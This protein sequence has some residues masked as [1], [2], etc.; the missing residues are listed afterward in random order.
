MGVTCKL[1]RLCMIGFATTHATANFACGELGCQG[2]GG[3]GDFALQLLSNYNLLS[4]TPM[5]SSAYQLCNRKAQLR[6]QGFSTGVQ[7]L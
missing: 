4:E 5:L 6:D 2:W 3:G 1:A 7:G